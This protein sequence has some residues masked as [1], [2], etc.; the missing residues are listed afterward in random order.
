MNVSAMQFEIR[1]I[2]NAMVRESALPDFVLASDVS[3]ESV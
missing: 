2:A 1:R 3:A